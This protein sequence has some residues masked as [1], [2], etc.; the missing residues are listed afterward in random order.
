[1]AS[2]SKALHVIKE[3]E[4]MLPTSGHPTCCALPTQRS[5][6]SAY[7]M[8][9]IGKQLNRLS[10][11]FRRE[12]SYDVTYNCIM[13]SLYA[14]FITL[15]LTLAASFTVVGALSTRR[16]FLGSAL[17]TAA[18]TAAGGGSGVLVSSSNW[19]TILPIPVANANDDTA[20]KLTF[21]PYQITPDASSALDPSLTPIDSNKL[22]Q[23]LSKT[24][25]NR[26]GAVWLGEHHNSV[27]DHKIQAKLIQDIYQQ[28]K[29]SGGKNNNNKM[30]VGLE[31]IQLQFQ[32]ILDAY[33]SKQISDEEMKQQVQWDTRWSWSFEG[34]L[35]IFQT[36]RELNIPLIAL[37]V[38]SEDL[39][40]VEVAG[41]PAL[42]RDQIQ[43]YIPDPNGFA[44][45]ARNRYYKTYVDYVISPSYELHKE[46][47][48]LRRTI[49]GQILEEDMPFARFFSGR[50]LWDE[51]MASN[52]YKW[53]VNNPGGLICCLVGSDHVKFTGGITGRFQRLA[54][55]QELD[56]TSVILNPT[57]IDT[58][59]SGSVSMLSNLAV[60][61]SGP[62]DLTLQLRY[63]KEGVDVGSKES[64]LPESTGGVLAL[65][66]YLVLSNM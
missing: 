35:P 51:S 32:P 64:R 60:L 43:K 54:Q 6:A 42:S 59:P 63:L 45:F 20:A 52:A 46:M 49:T 56:C 4:K 5:N 53:V 26:G 40:L 14:S 21:S 55:E 7:I 13:A 9:C 62:N 39:G 34:Y 28:R 61:A 50:I 19:P 27:E 17:R 15:L 1:M 41:L 16:D 25:G 66:D 37:N 11:H 10:V 29:L 12:N 23:I 8:S 30:A 65:A 36:C 48:I 47:G 44:Q 22:T 31:M 57:L 24:N 18:A 58:R 38:D 33:I 2:H 3:N